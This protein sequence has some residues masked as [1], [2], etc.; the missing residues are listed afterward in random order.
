MAGSFKSITAKSITR[1]TAHKEYD[2]Y[3]SQREDYTQCSASYD[4]V[5]AY[6]FPGYDLRYSAGVPFYY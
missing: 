3:F 4:G 2:L 1:H 6:G 5:E